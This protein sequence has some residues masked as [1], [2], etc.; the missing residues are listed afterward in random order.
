MKPI[1]TEFK[2]DDFLYRQVKRDGYIASYSITHIPSGA[3][4]GWELVVI[5]VSKARKVFGREYPDRE[6][7]PHDE[8]FG[9]YGWH[10]S[11]TD[12]VR[13]EA[14]YQELVNSPLNSLHYA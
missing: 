7:Y 6:V 13:C 8:A 14:R 10:Y 11:Q 3:N 5:R 1:K 9:T 4:K 12:P 2:I